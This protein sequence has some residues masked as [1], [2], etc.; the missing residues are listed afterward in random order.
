VTFVHSFSS[1]GERVEV[2]AEPAWAHRLVGAAIGR[3]SGESAAAT[4][5]DRTPTV[6][7]GI[8]ADRSPFRRD[9]LR[10]AGRGA[11]TDGQRTLLIDAGGSGFDLLLTASVDALTVTARYRPPRRTRVAN[12]LLADRFRLLAGQ[13]LVHY[14]V[15][16]RS[17]WRGRVPLHAS[18]LTTAYGV[19][20]C[21]GP[22]GV[23]KSTVVL[24]LLADGA[25]ATSDNLC[26]ADQNTCFG[27]L[28]PMRASSG[29]GSATSHGRVE[30]PMPRQTPQLCPDR[31]VLLERGGERTEVTQAK[32]QDAVRTLVSGTYAAGEL[33]R[34]W[35]F[36]ATMALATGIGPA[37]P[38][39][40]DVAWDYAGRL[41]C[42]RVRVG[43]GARVT[44]KQLCEEGL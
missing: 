27:L 20:L 4:D 7:I 15:L 19:P 11:Y 17:G 2:V 23:G 28:E 24:G 14:P 6:V 38:A 16:W 26:S 13:V 44:A 35:A 33:R 42:V 10:V 12:A 21:A 1:A 37:H 29:P 18:V 25:T 3:V 8:E 41:S 34:Y 31:L 43:D 9:G 5:R 32:P 30:R 36:A 40:T 39:I 22:S